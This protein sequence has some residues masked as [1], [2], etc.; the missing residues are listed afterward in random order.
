MDQTDG[1][2]DDDLDE[3]RAWA[4][5]LEKMGHNPRAPWKSQTDTLE[6]DN[7]DYI[8]DNGEEVWS[9]MEKK[10]LKNVIMV[11]VHTNMCVLGRPFGLRQM[12]KNGKNVVL[13]RDMTDTMYNPKR[14]PFVSHFQGT[15]LIIEHIEK[16]VCPT[17]TSNQLLGGQPFVFKH[18]QR[19]RAVFLVAEKIYNTR[20]TPV[21]YTHLTLPT[22][23]LV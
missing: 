17:I 10:G 15:D 12:S 16:F 2:E 9:I 6:I 21:S 1:G 7:R 20:S 11:G 22:S 23:D 13:V 8:S 3:H 5:K 18:D 4:K 19:P 14:W